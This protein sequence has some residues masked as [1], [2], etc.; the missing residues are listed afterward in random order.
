M[1]YHEGSDTSAPKTH[2]Y[3]PSGRVE[4]LGLG[5]KRLALCRLAADSTESLDSQL[6]A[7]LEDSFSPGRDVLVVLLAGGVRLL[8]HHFPQLGK[9]NQKDREGV[10]F[11]LRLKV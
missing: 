9:E 7:G 6:L 8:G 11:G 4:R 3:D 10:G 2:Y 1:N 5:V